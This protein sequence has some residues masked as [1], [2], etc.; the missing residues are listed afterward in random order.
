MLTGDTLFIGECGRTDLADGSAEDMYHSLFEKLMKIDDNV[1]VYPGH[2]Y[3]SASHSTIGAE[4][5]SNYTLEKR[6]LR[7]F[8]DF[9]REP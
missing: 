1:E 8:M 9:M 4:K 3:G 6:T 2:D 7:E 5:R